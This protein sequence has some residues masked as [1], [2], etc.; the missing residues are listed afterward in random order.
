MVMNY[1]IYP[2]SKNTN[3]FEDGLKFQDFVVDKILNELGIAISNYSSKYY[4]HKYGEN[5]QGIEIKLDRKADETNQL[6][7]EIAEKT[8]TLNPQFIPSGIYRN[9][10]SWLYI[11]GTYKQLYIFSKKVLVELHRSNK[12][13]EHEEPTIKAFF[14]PLYVCQIYSE[15]YF[16][17]NNL[18]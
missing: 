2:N 14:L 12:Y 9:D 11:Q 1:P 3:S 4:Q 13:H 17:Y 8:K 15:K 16:L 10:N 6:S 5:R 7:I 18:G